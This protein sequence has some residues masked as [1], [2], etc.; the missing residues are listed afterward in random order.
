MRASVQG[1]LSAIAPEY[2]QPHP[3]VF[4]AV[5]GSD[6]DFRVETNVSFVEANE[7]Y[8]RRVSPT[9]SLLSP[10]LILAHLARARGALRIASGLSSDVSLGSIG[11]VIG[12]NKIADVLRTHEGNR[13]V[14]EHFAEFTVSD[15]RAIGA[16]IASRQRD[17]VDLLKLV[18]GAKKFKEWLAKQQESND[19][20]AEYCREVSRLDWADKLPPKTIRWLLFNALGLAV[21]ATT[22]PVVGGAIGVGLSAAD[23]F[24]LDKLLKGWKPSQFVEGPLKEFIKI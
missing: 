8:H 4:D 9:D 15:S 14:L 11:A 19:L 6:G 21:G 13:D 16:A 22:S 24:L 1:I 10:A 17:F 12:A 18:Q 20:C 2:V 5:R 23:S 3:L 7:A